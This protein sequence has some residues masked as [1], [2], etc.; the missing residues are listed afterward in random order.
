M[1]KRDVFAVCGIRICLSVKGKEIGRAY[2]YVLRND[3]HEK[4]FGLLEDIF[5][6]KED[7]G[8]GFGKKLIELVI[9]EAK[10]QNCYKL[11]ATSRNE[12]E[13][14]HDMYTNL[15]FKLWGVEF[16]VNLE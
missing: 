2:L 15:G 5:V 16:R 9:K 7:R 13:R 3:L 10:K 8:R 14:L 11:V 4:P 1:I 6:N 12:R